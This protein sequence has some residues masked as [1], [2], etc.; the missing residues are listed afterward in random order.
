MNAYGKNSWLPEQSIFPELLLLRG[1]PI[2]HKGG[3]RTSQVQ[4]LSITSTFNYHSFWASGIW[5]G[6][7]LPFFSQIAS[8]ENLIQLKK[9]KS[10][11]A[12]CHIS[13]AVR[14]SFYFLW[15][16][17]F[18]PCASPSRGLFKP[19]IFPPPHQHFSS[20]LLHVILETG[21]LWCAPLKYQTSG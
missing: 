15:F 1:I 3:P 9:T 17:L 19:L 20:D 6:E 12:Q 2:T 4:S 16:L 11:R 7:I 5:I 21:A 10:R 14:D 13:L 18:N 8:D